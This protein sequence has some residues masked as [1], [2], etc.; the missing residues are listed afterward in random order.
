MIFGNWAVKI[1][2]IVEEFSKV[3]KT[4]FYLSKGTVLGEKFLQEL[5]FSVNIAQWA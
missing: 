3:V 1:S 2:P 5:H 4:A